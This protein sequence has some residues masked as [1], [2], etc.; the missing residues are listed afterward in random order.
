MFQEYEAA[1]LARIHQAQENCRRVDR[2]ASAL[3]AQ[4]AK[5]HSIQGTADITPMSQQE[6]GKATRKL[7]VNMK[8]IHGEIQTA[9]SVGDVTQGISKQ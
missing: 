6:I 7:L 3:M 4:D 8:S 1:R 2:Y 9:L 5:K